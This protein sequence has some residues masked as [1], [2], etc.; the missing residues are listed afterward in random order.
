M[1]F[2]RFFVWCTISE[3]PPCSPTDDIDESHVV[4]ADSPTATP[5]P[6]EEEL[7][8]LAAYTSTWDWGQP[9]EDGPLGLPTSTPGLPSLPSLSSFSFDG[10]TNAL[11][12]TLP[13]LDGPLVPPAFAPG[14]PLQPSYLGMPV[15][16]HQIPCK[17]VGACQKPL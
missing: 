3:F 11:G 5:E 8:E 10:A 17:K 14:L 7:N 13:V 9:M 12:L 6:M 15:T 2:C 16:V 1:L 4:D